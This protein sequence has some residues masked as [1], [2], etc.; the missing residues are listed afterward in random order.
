MSA[1]IAPEAQSQL[2][3][4]VLWS[5]AVGYLLSIIISC[6]LL[7]H[8]A[9][10]YH[11]TFHVQSDSTHE[12]NKSKTAYRLIMTYLF[13]IMLTGFT[14]W[15]RTNAFH[16]RSRSDIAPSECVVGAILNYFF[17]ALNYMLSN[18]IFLHRVYIIFDDSAYAYKPWIY[19]SFFIWIVVSI[20]VFVSPFLIQIGLSKSFTL[21]YDPDTDIAFCAVD[22]LS[23]DSYFGIAGYLIAITQPIDAAILLFMFVRGLWKLNK[24]MMKSFVQNRISKGPGNHPPV[25]HVAVNSGSEVC[26]DGNGREKGVSMDIVLEEWGRQ[27]TFVRE[28]QKDEVQR[29]VTLHNLIKKQTILV[30]VATGSTCCI[31]LGALFYGDFTYENGWDNCVNAICVWMMLDTSKKYWRICQKYGLCYWCYRKTNKIGM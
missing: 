13:S 15:I 6:I 17:S 20:T 24:Q 27:K 5:S 14:T 23:R 9:L 1:T 22:S 7:T 31:W 12:T 11:K 3:T 8:L 19:K 26:E 4:N 16:I 30:C 21:Q 18:I 28:I 29:I 2:W 10:A 25:V